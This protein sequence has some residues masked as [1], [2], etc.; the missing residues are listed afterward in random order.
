MHYDPKKGQSDIDRS[1][2]E[3]ALEDDLD[4]NIMYRIFQG[5]YNENNQSKSVNK[6]MKYSEGKKK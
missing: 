6:R 5:F 1:D 2:V 4:A 3:K